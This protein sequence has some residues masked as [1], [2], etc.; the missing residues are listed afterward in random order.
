MRGTEPLDRRIER[1][2]RTGHGFTSLIAVK[3]AVELMILADQLRQP[4]RIGACARRGKAAILRV[5]S[6]TTN[7][8]DGRFTKDSYLCGNRDSKEAVILAR[9][10]SHAFPS[11]SARA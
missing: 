1:D 4:S 8:I 10:R 2:H 6:V 3:A 7:S 11:A 5:Q 9:S